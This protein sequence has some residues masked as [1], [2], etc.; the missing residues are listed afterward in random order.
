MSTKIRKP[1]ENNTYDAVIIGNI[2]KER[3]VDYLG[4]VENREGGA[5]VYA[6]AACSSNWSKVA[7]ATKL[8]K[9]DYEMLRPLHS[10]FSQVFYKFNGQTA[11]IENETL[12]EEV[13]TICKQ[14]GAPFQISDIPEV[15]SYYY[16]FVGE[17]YGEIPLDLIEYY[18]HFGKI[19]VDASV[20]VKRINPITKE[21]EYHDYRNKKQL[22]SYC[23]VLKASMREA[24]ILT[25][26][27]KPEEAARII[28]SWGA[29]EILLTNGTELYLLDENGE[30]WES[31]IYETASIGRLYR[32]TT[33]FVT[34]VTQRLTSDPDTALYCAGA[35]AM[36]KVKRPG[37]IR[38]LRKDIN[39]NLKYFY[40]YLP[41]RY[42]S[43]DEK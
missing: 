30:F 8:A 39:H 25:G 3:N 29:S 32:G 2:A 19:A 20:F 28:Q 33:V 34:Y 6:A 35:I 26:T 12:N 27:D 36:C 40:Y 1:P 7:V 10:K 24:K 13:K 4:N 41:V 31:Y 14:Q 22:A 5:I 21:A 17:F 9:E 18:A 15:K 16:I 23:D 43:T 38:C 37:P 42:P 11:S